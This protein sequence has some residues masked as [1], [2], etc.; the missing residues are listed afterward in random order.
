MSSGAIY[1]GYWIN[2]SKITTPFDAFLRLTLCI[3]KG[4]VF[5]ATITLESQYGNILVAFLALFV[6][7][8]GSLLWNLIC[9]GIH[10]LRSSLDEH[11]GLHHQI[12]AILPT[13]LTDSSMFWRFS[14][15]WWHWRHRTARVGTRTTPLI[16][17]CLVHFGL[18]TVAGLFSS[19]IVDT[20][21]EALL[22]PSQSC[23]WHDTSVIEK[24]HAGSFTDN[25]INALDALILSARTATKQGQ[26]YSRSCYE[27]IDDSQP[28]AST[29]SSTVIPFLPSSVNLSAACPFQAEACDGPAISFD[30]GWIDSHDHLGVNAAPRDRVQIRKATTCAPVP[31]EQKYSSNWFESP[32]IPGLQLQAYNLGEG[33][34]LPVSGLNATIVITNETLW[35]NGAYTPM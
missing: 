29:C 3:G 19:R 26:A 24:L 9:F 15:L 21:R 33:T 35:T 16:L 11:D 12:Q 22:L 7:F 17:A 31:V 4:Y 28:S 2:W 13:G 6:S 5:G 23:G 32:L 27:S 18:F 14:Q 8:T 34:G 30:S 10:Q 25:N 1:T 20:A